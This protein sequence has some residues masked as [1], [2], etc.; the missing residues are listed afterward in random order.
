[1]WI[2][3]LG[4]WCM[5]SSWGERFLRNWGHPNPL[6][7]DPDLRL[8]T[9]T[10]KNSWSQSCMHSLNSKAVA[11]MSVGGGSMG[12]ELLGLRTALEMNIT[13]PTLLTQSTAA[14]QRSIMYA[15]TCVDLCRVWPGA[16]QEA[17]SVKQSNQQQ[18]TVYLS[19]KPTLGSCGHAP[20]NIMVKYPNVCIHR[21]DLNDWK[22]WIIW[23]H[24]H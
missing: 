13:A 5:C 1:M 2:H 7:G 24:H 16:T 6:P 21:N 4:H 22:M 11:I 14:N 10:G 3:G 8:F 17:D 20:C 18:N 23:A 9:F 15:C 19:E 12:R